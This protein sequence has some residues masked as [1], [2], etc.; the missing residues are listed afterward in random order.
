MVEEASYPRGRL[1]GGASKEGKMS[2][3]QVLAAKRRQQAA[4]KTS[5]TEPRQSSAG[6]D[7]TQS[8]NKLR[9]SQAKAAAKKGEEVT[10]VSNAD[11]VMLD[12]DQIPASQREAKEQKRDEEEEIVSQQNLRAQPSAFASTLTNTSSS[13]ELGSSSL[14]MN[15]RPHPKVFDFSE[16]S[17]DDLVSKAQS[18]L[19]G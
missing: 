1:L 19:R 10:P 16:P 8:L 6:D 13:L 12:S 17:P 4:E 11:T 9:I 15:S 7:Y 5:S 18:R 3:L 2:K 14:P